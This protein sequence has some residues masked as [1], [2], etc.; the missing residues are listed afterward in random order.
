MNSMTCLKKKLLCRM[1]LA[2]IVLIFT[3]LALLLPLAVA[4]PPAPSRPNIIILLQDDMGIGDFSAAGN[5]ILKTPNLDRLQAQSVGF[6]QFHVSPM[7]TPTRGAL[8]TGVHCMRNGARAVGTD[9]T[10]LRTDLP[11]LAELFKKANYKT[12]IFGKWHVGDNFPM[13][14]QDRGFDEALWFRQ[15]AADKVGDYWGNDYFDD[16]YLLNGVTKQYLGYCGDVWFNEAMTWMRRQADAQEPFFAF[17]PNNLAHSPYYAPERNRRKYAESFKKHQTEL[18]T[19]AAMVDNIDENV[20]RLDAF[21]QETGLADNTILVYLHDNGGSHGVQIFNANV[22]GWKTQL[23][24]GGHRSPLFIRWPQGK[25]GEGRVINGLTQV[26]DILPTLLELTSIPKPAN[27]QFDGI[28][29]VPAI[30]ARETIPDRTLVVQYG[31]PKSGDACVLWRHWRLISNTA[32]YDLEADP[33]QSTNVADRYPEI[34]SK[35]RGKY[36]LW[37]QSIQPELAMRT[38]VVI[39]NAAENPLTLSPGSW[40]RPYFVDNDKIRKGANAVGSYN[41]KVSQS[42]SYEI[43]LRRWPEEVDLPIVAASPPVALTDTLCHGKEIS[44][45]IAL[46]I[47]KAELNI[48]DQKFERDVTAQDKAIT[49]RCDLPEGATEL[50]A[51]FHGSAP[52]QK[53]GAYCVVIRRL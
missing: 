22:R 16:H 12:G 15:A 31:T 19:Y 34:V 38:P 49:F 5:P 43:S 8:L 53:W 14:P 40:Q 45:G 26:Q 51:L 30:R 47:S 24:E 50:Q 28:S 41:L 10:H 21:L 46:P 44:A 39:G 20:G 7:C 4:G 17:I 48:G 36:D 2:P 29:L 33:M 1:R 52:T 18:L 23:W 6:S 3:A 32:L 25:I 9:A 35:M 37:W 13:R 11:C 27:N 42:G